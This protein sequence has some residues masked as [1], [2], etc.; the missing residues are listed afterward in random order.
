MLAIRL[1]AVAV[2]A[3][4]IFCAAG[5]ATGLS[6]ADIAPFEKHLNSKYPLSESQLQQLD[7]LIRAHPDEAYLHYLLA[8]H[9]RRLGYTQLADETINAAHNRPDAS[10]FFKKLMEQQVANAE[11]DRALNV[12]KYANHWHSNSDIGIALTAFYFNEEALVAPADKQTQ[13][14]Q[15]VTVEI[16]RLASHKETWPPGVGGLLGHIEY[17]QGHDTR[18]IEFAD[19]DLRKDPH[20][21]LANQV[22]GLALFQ[23][24]NM[25]ASIQP[26]SEAFAANPE[27]GRTTPSYAQAL[28]ACGQDKQALAPAFYALTQASDAAQLKVFEKRLTRL[29]LRLDGPFVDATISDVTRRARWTSQFYTFYFALAEAYEQ[30]DKPEQALRCYALACS[31]NK[32]PT[33]A[34]SRMGR[35]HQNAGRYK[36]AHDCY[37]LSALSNQ[38]NISAKLAFNRLADRLA[39]RDNDVAWKLRDWLRRTLCFTGKRGAQSSTGS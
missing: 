14:K 4:M 15:K 25:K 17:T 10:G 30:M 33:T 37:A 23:Q 21:Q 16:S 7:A 29:L 27:N 19:I 35:L 22:K 38:E 6:D 11:I 32:A 20:L 8:R 13:L 31:Y 18:A 9:Q 28:I 12:M 2:L 1:I 39:N 24:G 26:L 5:Q 34:L 3:S 36:E